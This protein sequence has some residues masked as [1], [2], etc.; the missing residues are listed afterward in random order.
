MVPIQDWTWPYARIITH[1]PS[2]DV[3]FHLGNVAAA[4]YSVQMVL[5]VL[6]PQ[7]K[8]NPTTKKKKP[9]NK[10]KTKTKK[11]KTADGTHVFKR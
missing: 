2:E 8:H 1:N 4:D 11:T 9:P 3:P 6:P 10:E 7:P 5:L